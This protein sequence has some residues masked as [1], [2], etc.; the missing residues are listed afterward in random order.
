MTTIVDLLE[1]SAAGI[2]TVVFLP[3]ERPLGIG[4]LWAE[5]A[6]AAT[7]VSRRAGTGGAVGAFLA[8]TRAAVR[9]ALGVWASGN[10]LVSLPLRA[11]RQ[12]QSAWL[13]HVRRMCRLA[14]VEVV[15][16]PA[17][18]VAELAEAG[19]TAVG[20]EALPDS[21]R[22]AFPAPGAGD[23][24]QFTSGSTSHPK[25]VVLSGHALAENVLAIRN[26]VD[27]GHA[28]VTVS[29]LPLSH[30]MG[31]VGMLLTPLVAAARQFGGSQAVIMEPEYFMRD[32][33]RWLQ[34][35]TKFGG[36]V[37]TVPN[38][39]F[40]LA[41]RTRV[42]HSGVDVS[43]LRICITGAERIR[44]DTIRAFVSAFAALGLDERV[45]C[46][47]YGM[48]ENGLAVTLVRPDEHWRAVTVSD[49]AGVGTSEV[50]ST[51]RPLEGV[52]V[53]I[54]S[55]DQPDGEIQVASPSLLDR[56]LG[57][58]VPWTA[59]GW[60]R[61]RDSGFMEDGELFVLGRIDDTIDVGGR[62][63]H[64]EDIEGAC[65]HAELGPNAVAAIPWADRRVAVVAEVQRATA[66]LDSIAGDVLEAVSRRTGVV[67]SAIFFVRRGMLRRTT[68]GK[69]RRG[70][71]EKRIT[72]GDIEIVARFGKDA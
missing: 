28:D 45:L 72:A 53:R 46:P 7:A 30:D 48:A 14:G 55:P 29:W 36:T 25:G 69:L 11:P 23:L 31:L 61:T 47:A 41:T 8:N 34:A 52:R 20:Y 32:P 70:E 9:G 64:P 15:L 38:S 16:A 35:C 68:S 1:D 2:G 4:A 24:V 62:N 3:D 10:T 40:D 27:L 56:Y 59:D 49:P 71:L 57:A 66:D 50:V 58:E 26:A 21:G 5:S 13:G 12:D 63:V 42:R 17:A 19:L 6:G 65:E 39:A 67:I 22:G 51:G 37:T 18:Q 44:P 33:A 54:D 43:S 60:F